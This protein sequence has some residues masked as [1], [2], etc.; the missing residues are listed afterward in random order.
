MLELEKER[1]K[2]KRTQVHRGQKETCKMW[3]SWCHSEA[4]SVIKW[5][6][7]IDQEEELNLVPHQTPYFNTK[8]KWMKHYS[9]KALNTLQQEQVSN[10][11]HWNEKFL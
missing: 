4:G 11:S 10:M 2:K 6:D 1:K 3:L 5:H 9:Q 8:F 7:T